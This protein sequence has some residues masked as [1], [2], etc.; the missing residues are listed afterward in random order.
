M[1]VHVLSTN[2]ASF[3]GSLNP[4]ATSEQR[5]SSQYNSLKSI[6]EGNPSSKSQLDPVCM[7]QGSYGWQTAT[8]DINDVDI[9]LLCRGLFLPADPLAA[10][11]GYGWSRDRIFGAIESAICADGRYT[12]KLVPAKPTSMCVKLDLGIK[13]EILPVV[14]NAELPVG[15]TEPFYLW[16]PSTSQ[17]QLGYARR[18][19]EYLSFKNRPH[20]PL[21]GTGTDGNFIPMVKV[22]KHLRDMAGLDAVS[23][24]IETLL[25]YIANQRFLGSPAVYIPAVLRAITAQRADEW[26]GQRVMTPCGDRDIFTPTEW[27]RSSWNSF[28]EAASMWATLA[29]IAASNPDRGVAIT[30][31]K[32]LL[33]SD[34]FPALAA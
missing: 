16:R 34:Y 31:W 25:Y 2:F 9:V 26:Y 27:T 32:H 6:L 28:Y 5:A 15:E 14:R 29:E 17:W 33:G 10:A 7:L 3:F 20:N 1:A 4:S 19:R 24:H 8:H 12:W 11:G 30:W 18:H 23:F 21:A 13:I 22:V